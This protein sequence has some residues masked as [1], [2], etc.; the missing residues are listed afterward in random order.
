MSKIVP[1]RRITL[2]EVRQLAIAARKKISQAA[3]A[4]EREATLYLHWSAGHYHQHYDDYHI[5]IDEDGS[6]YA[7]TDDLSA[8]LSHTWRRNSGAVGIV[9]ACG[10]FATVND[11]G[12]EPPTDAQIE[13]MSMVIAVIADVLDIP[14][15]ADHVMTHAEAADL[16]GYGPA[17]TCERWDLAILKNGDKWMSGGNTLR[18]KA[19]W[20]QQ[21]GI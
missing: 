19:N 18:G 5:S 4:L 11:L 3:Q 12:G 16:D 9:L 15:D 21:N 10:A 2:A 20:Y 1:G 7:T 6:M 17:T 14:I 8:V 13:S